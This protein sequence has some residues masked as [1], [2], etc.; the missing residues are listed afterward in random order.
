MKD[1]NACSDVKRVEQA[2]RPAV[3]AGKRAALAAEVHSLFVDTSCLEAHVIR[4]VWSKC[5]VLLILSVLILSH[6]AFPQTSQ[7]P[8]LDPNQPLETRLDDLIRRMTLQ[9]K[10]SQMQ[11]VAPAI[12]RLHIPAYNWWNEGLHG[13]AR[14]GYA[15]VFP[16]AIGLAATWDDQLMFRVADVISTEA[17]AKYNDAIAHGNRDRYFGL[18][19]WS[20]NINIFRDPR[21]GRGQ[22]T[23][24]EDPFLT[25]RLGVAFVKGLQGNDPKY[26][27]TIS[28]PKHYAVHSGPEVLRHSFNVPVSAHDLADTY[29]PAFRMTVVDGH[30]QS[31]MCAYNAVLGA[32]ACGSDVLYTLLRKQWGFDGY[33]VS[34]CGAIDDIFRG[35]RYAMTIEQASALAVKA[36]TDLSCGDE[37]QFLVGAVR[38]RLLSEADLNLAVRRLMRARFQL[39][40][41]DPPAN[42]PFSKITMAENTSPEH[43]RLS[44]QAARESIVLLK[45]ANNFLPLAGRYKKIAVVGPDA[46]TLDVLLGN[47]N[48]T[49]LRPVTPLAGIRKRFGDANVTYVP[50]SLLSETSATPVP[51]SALR[52]VNAEY[53]LNPT[54][55]GDPVLR[56]GETGLHY[57]FTS[58]PKELEP[59]RGIF[60]VRWTGQ[61]TA[62]QTAEYRLGF[63]ARDGVRVYL[64]GALLV[65]AWDRRPA[66]TLTAPVQLT[67]GRT[68][69]VVVEHYQLRDDSSAHLVWAPP[70]LLSSAVQAARNADVVIAFVGIS[71]Q[72]EGEEMTDVSAPGFF[73]GDRVDLDLPKPQEDMLKAVAATGKPLIVVLLNGSALAVNWAQEHAAAVLDAWY[74]GEE[75][76][77]A[78]ADVIA[79][80]Y[81]P[82]GRLPLTFY[83]SIAQLPPF[84]GYSMA[85]RTYRYFRGQ[86]LY[87]FGD[88]LSFSRFEYS[89][90]KL[91]ASPV[92]IGQPLEV[93]VTVKNTSQRAGDEVVELYLDRTVSSPGMPFRTL[94][95]FQRIHL[96]GGEAK[97]VTLKLEPRQLAFV[98]DKGKL[99]A[100]PGQYTISVGGQQPAANL[101]PGL[102]VQQAVA[103]AGEP[104]VF[105]GR[106]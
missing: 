66:R 53:F 39:G 84:G 36:G 85:G 47:Y 73:G 32:P 1:S 52:D 11:D 30:A 67:A 48:G 18:T 4:I 57:D 9:E 83:K 99:I 27:K 61:L 17:R 75:G 96:N 26:F 45:N 37:Y 88:G 56:R 81:N 25:G 8:Y 78:I 76:G 19:F 46:D 41:F 21:W 22:E 101:A 58:P 40:M 89:D 64:D 10:A 65:D 29:T 38:N 33:V 2:F 62:P 69:K 106:E 103:L 80:D 23:Y 97:Q 94:Q 105:E 50:G 87:R 51:D 77:T 13:V 79:G 20:P 55:S 3:S 104:K 5:A 14:A 86:P 91:S 42:V 93:Q 16:Q 98:D 60:S 7:P 74:P 70:D 90:L 95:G 28:T 44:L 15:T 100:S 24:G 43:R 49:P 35:H 63:A 72:L 12:E 92:P 59:G 54:L 82:A 31:I 34:D 71:P 6:N 102:V 68:Y